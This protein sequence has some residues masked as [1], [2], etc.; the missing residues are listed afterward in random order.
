MG[1]SFFIRLR[2]WRRRA[3]GRGVRGQPQAPAGRSLT[4]PSPTHSNNGGDTLQGIYW[5]GTG[6]G[7]G[8]ATPFPPNAFSASSSKSSWIHRVT[9]VTDRTYWT[10]IPCFPFVSPATR[11]M[12]YLPA[13]APSG[14]RQYITCLVGDKCLSIPRW[15]HGPGRSKS[16]GCWGVGLLG[17]PGG[18]FTTARVTWTH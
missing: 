16:A 1:V 8:S 7:S 9:M 3:N 18:G 6:F 11:I 14:P 12:F 10:S 17:F 2:S 15:A 4:G 5:G 13:T